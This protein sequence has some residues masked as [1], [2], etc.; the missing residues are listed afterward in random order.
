MQGVPGCVLEFGLG[1][2]RTYDH[3]RTLL[4]DREIFVFEREVSA[5]PDCVPDADHLFEGDFADSIPRALATLKA[6]AALAHCD[7]G[8]GDGAESRARADWLGPAMAPLLVSGAIVASDQDLH[9]ARFTPIALPQ[10]INARRY[11]VYRHERA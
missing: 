2:G 8:S 4:P 3:L 10:G 11:F 1:N 9:R 6:R 5:H 7:I